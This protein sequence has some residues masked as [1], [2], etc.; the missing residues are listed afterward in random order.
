[1]EI[2][3]YLSNFNEHNFSELNFLFW[4]KFPENKFLFVQKKKLEMK[5][6]FQLIMGVIVTLATLSFKFAGPLILKFLTG[7]LAEFITKLG[8]GKISPF[9]FSISLYLLI[10]IFLEEL[11]IKYVATYFGIDSSK[12]PKSIMSAI[13]KVAQS[14]FQKYF[15]T[16]IGVKTPS[17]FIAKTAIIVFKSTSSAVKYLVF[18]LTKNTFSGINHYLTLNA[19]Q[20]KIESVDESKLLESVKPYS[21]IEEEP[22]LGEYVDLDE[23]DIEELSSYSVNLN[24]LNDIGKSVILESFS[25]SKVNNEEVEKEFNDWYKQYRYEDELLE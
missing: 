24:S 18:D 25:K 19:L 22:E 16:V 6:K 2:I 3:L 21:S 9:I 11:L 23:E 17:D 5:F 15:M 14:S 8:L 10:F 1:M 20:S 13:S 4:T 7:R 12:L